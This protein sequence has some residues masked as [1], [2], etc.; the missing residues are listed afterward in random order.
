MNNMRATLLLFC[1]FLFASFSFAQNLTEQIEQL[2]EENDET[3]QGADEQE[4]W[5]RLRQTP[6]NLNTATKEELEQFSFLTPLQVEN[7]L[8]YIYI[9]GEMKSLSE[10]Q[11]VEEMDKRTIDRLLPY[12]CVR[13]VPKQPHYPS[14]KALL[15]NGKQEV[16][17]RL[18]V[19]FY[20]RDG[21]KDSFLGSPVY[22][23]LR[24]DFQ[25]RKYFRFGITAEKDA[26][27]PLFALN[28]RKGYDSYSVHCLIQGLGR[29]KT[30][31]LG[32]YRLHFGQGLVVSTDFLTGK[33]YSLLTVNKS[34]GGIKAHTST[35]EYN[36]F[37]GA[38]VTL[39]L[40]PKWDISAFY[41]YRSM[42]GT[43]S[44]G[45]ITSIDKD[46]LHRSDKEEAK[47]NA[48]SLQLAGGH[49]SYKGRNLQ[50]GV[51]G[52]YYFFSHPYEPE[53]RTY[54]HYTL[55]GNHFYNV[56]LDYRYHFRHWMLTGEAAL[57]KQGFALLNKLSYF[58]AS[59][60]RLLVV[61]RYYAHNYWAL[62][63]RTFGESS[64]PQ[65]ENGWYVAGEFTQLS[66]WTFFVSADFFSFPFERYRISKPSQ[67]IDCLMQAA[68]H[69]TSTVT[70]YVN[71]RYKR[72]E[73]D[74]T[75]SGGSVTLPTYQHRWRYR[76]N[77]TTEHLRLQTTIDYTLFT[78][79]G[80][81]EQGFGG[82]QEADYRFAFPLHLSL[83]GTY[84]HTN[85][86]DARV[87]ASEQ[88]LLY[89]FYTP[90]Y[91]GRGFRCSAAVHY[92]AGKHFL[93]IAKWGETIYQDRDGIGS[94][95][96][97]IEG[98]KKADLQLQL[99]MKF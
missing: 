35:D 15:K 22:H 20:Q 89:S 47:R 81:S 53:E 65:N 64:T 42:D 28:N 70:M 98:N 7:I 95:K 76:L 82:T 30:W 69:P 84:F 93:L 29:I 87:Y 39:K 21:Y 78:T 60:C 12:V 96:E 23:S 72:K 90:S 55:R 46:G 49:L 37:R 51:A 43:V 74:V 36:F 45:V 27:E 32:D 9:Y 61:H 48:F 33:S 99:R 62:F 25:C 92:E 67:G 41:S 38:A 13:D 63:A 5:A 44:D 50:L 57:G 4:E 11:L 94:G 66:H 10:L 68:Y 73:R 91:D 2:T 71:Y 17:T 56:G 6:L 83:Q 19:P 80:K 59:D 8:A 26:G 3:I 58:P 86:Y 24:Y 88:G 52:I 54:N 85:D 34:G 1:M 97:R 14:L 75:G 40:F 16:L 77:Y 79:N 18:D 31:A